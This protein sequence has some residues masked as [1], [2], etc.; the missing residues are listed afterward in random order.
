MMM[1]SRLLKSWAMP[2]VSWPIACIFCDWRNCSSMARRSV[3]S[4]L[5]ATK[6]MTSPSSFFTGAIEAISQ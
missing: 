2:P 4:S 6:L 3:T 1:V 5:T